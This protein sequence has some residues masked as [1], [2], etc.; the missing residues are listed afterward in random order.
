MLALYGSQSFG[1]G[2]LSGAFGYGWHDITT[3]RVVTV[4][5][6]DILAGK[7]PAHE[8]AGRI[9]AGYGVDAGGQYELTP[10][11]AFAGESL[12][13]PGCA[14]SAI[15]GSANFALTYAAHSADISHLEL[16]ARLGR[17]FALD[18]GVLE[19]KGIAAWAHQLENDA[20]AQV[21]FTSLPGSSFTIYGI[22]PA[23]D[24]RCWGWIWKCSPGRASAMASR[25]AARLARVPAS[26]R[27]PQTSPSIG[28]VAVNVRFWRKA[29]VSRI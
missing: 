28:K 6:T 7:P 23:D 21:A 5:G 8:W 11:A 2:Y 12:A 25:C 13:T 24:P 14:E 4:A 26:S 18:D 9:E 19:V 22:K 1:S 20:L 3:T 27:V 10:F 16:G 15:S 17:T 29:D